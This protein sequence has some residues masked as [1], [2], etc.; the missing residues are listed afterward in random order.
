[1]DPRPRRGDQ[2][3]LGQKN[4]AQAIGRG[5]HGLKSGDYWI[6]RSL[7]TPRTPETPSAICAA[8]AVLAWDFTLPVRCTLSFVVSTWMSSDFRSDLPISAAFTLVVMA[9]SS[10]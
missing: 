10:T 6:A 4:R 1:M 3:R 7:V 8:S 2:I 5:F 9:A